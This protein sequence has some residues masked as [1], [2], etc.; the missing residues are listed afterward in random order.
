MH[1]GHSSAAWRGWPPP[2]VVRAP[3]A[4]PLA[5]LLLLVRSAS[6]AVPLAGLGFGGARCCAD[7]R[8]APE[9]HAAPVAEHAEAR[10][11]R[12]RASLLQRS[13]R[14][15]TDGR[16]AAA[17]GGEDSGAAGLASAGPVSWPYLPRP[18]LFS[19]SDTLFGSEAN[20]HKAA[21]Q[22]ACACLNWSS[23]YASR[24][25]VCTEGRELPLGSEPQ[26]LRQ[27][28]CSGVFE[29]LNASFCVNRYE[30]EGSGEQWCYV[31]KECATFSGFAPG[32]VERY[33]GE[34]LAIKTC[35]AE[36][37]ALLQRRE[38]EELLHFAQAEGLDVRWLLRIAYPVQRRPEAD[39]EALWQSATASHSSAASPRKPS[40][41]STPSVWLADEGYKQG[42]LLVVHKQR[43]WLLGNQSELDPPMRWIQ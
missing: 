34:P 14:S 2:M 11:P 36:R 30:G 17:A 40:G 15:S 26:G 29:K 28:L 18:L 1:I 16:A 21:M 32:G 27:Q 13:A 4:V 35:S 41:P 3:L 22:A 5:L 37:D 42:M 12:V 6:V 7:G 23:V 33:A 10:R 9:A 43:A 31:D 8:G 25:G 20:S 39:I 38:P 24:K 19:A